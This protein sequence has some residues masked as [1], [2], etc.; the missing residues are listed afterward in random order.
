MARL[1]SFLKL[2]VDQGASD[3]HFHAGNVPIIR[4]HGD[5]IPLPF[6]S[7]SGDEASRFVHE[8]MSPAQQEA[9]ADQ[10]ELD[11]A[12]TTEGVGRFRVHVFR[13]SHGVGAVFRVIPSEVPTI[14]KLQ[15][16]AVVRKLATHQNGLVLITGPTGSGKTTTLAAIIHEINATQRRHIITIEDPVEF[17]HGPLKSVVTQRQVGV[18]A[19]SFLQAHRSSLRESPDVL[20]VGEMRDHETV[21]LA[22]SAAESGVL[23][24]G[25]LHANSASRAV[26]RILNVCPDDSREQVRAVLSILL[27]GVVAQHL[28]RRATGDGRVAVLEVLLQSYG[29][30][31]MIRENK[32]HQLDAYLR[33]VDPATTGMQSLDHALAQAVRLGHITAEEAL[34]GANH[35]DDLRKSIAEFLE[36]VDA[37]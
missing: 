11:F 31:N 13:Q 29:V 1:D 23:V 33:S 30:S 24:F 10:G 17:I 9:F 15:L 3:L 2:V 12:Y 26:D 22:L 35:P 32:L 4:H 7:L 8:I 21:S 34:R 25:T 19:E 27:R 14:D 5:L 6:R 37:A 36:E 20:V 28:S 18:H 16:P